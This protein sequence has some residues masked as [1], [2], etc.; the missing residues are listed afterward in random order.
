[1]TERDGRT[2]A[3]PLSFD[4]EARLFF[5]SWLSR[6]RVPCAPFHL[7]AAFVLRGILDRGALAACLE[8]IVQR[9]DSLRTAFRGM[10]ASTSAAASPVLER[11]C[12]AHVG[13][14]SR[15]AELRRIFTEDAVRPF[16]YQRPPLMRARV[17]TLRPDEHVLL[18]VLHHLVADGWSLRVLGKELAAGYG[19]RA[20]NGESSPVHA[21]AAQYAD[22]VRWQRERLQG[23][24]LRRLVSHVHDRYRDFDTLQA[25]CH[26]L[27]FAKPRGGPV[28]A[29]GNASY[30]LSRATTDRAR[31]CAQER[32]L[33]LYML[34]LSAVATLVHA[35][36][37]RPSLGIWGHFANRMRPEFEHTIGWCSTFRLLSVD[38]TG[39]PDIG[40]VL[41][42]TRDAVL[43][44][45]ASQELPFALLWKALRTQDGVAVKAPRLFGEAHISF[46]FVVSPRPS[47]A[48]LERL[49]PSV[50]T[51]AACER[52]LRLTALDDG[53]D[54]TL[55][56]RYSTDVLEDGGVR[57]MLNDIE[58]LVVTI[59]ASPARRV[60]E[61][62][63]PH[64]PA[65]ESC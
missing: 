3:T 53:E 27:P 30:T 15:A 42:Q 46:N 44:A 5:E 2:E 43:D 9:H 55:L 7:H 32:R 4:Q 21:P 19:D 40:A 57:Q 6:R 31:R 10:T 64:R 50:L 60:A 18:V 65:L 12:L 45:A 1:M 11:D 33:S 28:R 51:P 47:T 54:I 22:F 37:R 16:D 14:A 20:A 59:C 63:E 36:T 13:E 25:S 62:I 34:L 24:V 8:A 23:D 39:N 48:E 52:A 26:D 58:R 35:Y 41:A 61:A 49:P 56:A 38:F 17:V 29:A